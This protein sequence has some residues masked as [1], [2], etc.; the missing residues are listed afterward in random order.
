MKH[1]NILPHVKRP[2]RY[3]GQE[4]NSDHSPTQSSNISFALVFPDLYEIG[5]SHQGLQ[6]LYHILN[7]SKRLSAERCFCPDVDVEELLRRKSIPLITLESGR[8]LSTFDVV[9]ITVPHELCYTNILTILNRSFIPFFAANRQDKHPIILGGGACALNPEPVAELFDAILIGDG[10][11]AIVEIGKSLIESGKGGM[12]RSE[13]IEVLADIK[14]VYLPHRYQ[15]IYTNNGCIQEMRFKGNHP[16]TVAKRVLANLSDLDHL[17]H[18]I[19]PNAKIVHDRLGIE[20]ARGCTRGCRFCQ[21]GMTYRPVRERTVDQIM[22]VAEKGIA[23][24]GF[25][26]IALLSLSTGDYSC[27]P[28]LLPKLMDRFSHDYVSVA[29]P[30]MRVGTLDQKVMDEI[31]R[32]RKT[33]FTLAPEAG[34]ER[35]RKAINKGI[36]EEDLLNTAGDAFNLGWNLIKLYFMIGLPTE[37]PEDIDAII[38]LAKKTAIA[39]N[40]KGS[41]RKRVTV[42]VGTFVP[43]P[44]TPYQ[45]EPQI[46]ISQSQERI[47]QLKKA[48]PRKGFNLKWHD[49]QQSYLE[50]VFARGDRQLLPLIISAWEQGARLD[51]WSEHF[52]LQV[53]LDAAKRCALDL[54]FYL[55]ERNRD[56]CLPWSHLSSGVL[57]EFLLD[58]L[59]KTA[60]GEYTPDCRYHECQQCGLCDFDTIAPIVHN[61]SFSTTTATSRN[62]IVPPSCS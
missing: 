13:Q 56:E 16:A 51:S 14:G 47:I 42:S 37:T 36:S 35:L 40:V 29:L 61:N 7:N 5:M 41:G 4:F 48:L 53:W 22:K 6:I 19:V 31:K 10:E 25:D 45:W 58:E 52:N 34:S 38:E 9:G 54:D 15:P 46:T 11:E 62:Q 30:S 17:S 60:S 1:D 23:H 24:S 18:P 59:D 33:G 20:V 26:E 32:V 57:S 2:G 12:S 43:K 21:A 44:H 50:G 39:G 3:I 55:R 8:P 27:L 28:E 49:P